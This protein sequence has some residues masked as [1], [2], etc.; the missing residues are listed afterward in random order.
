MKQAVQ[1]AEPDQVC[2]PPRGGRGLKHA[3]PSTPELAYR[4]PP[5]RGAWIETEYRVPCPDCRTSRPPRG[6]RGLKPSPTSSTGAG[7]SVAPRAGGVD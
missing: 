7:Y 4:S 5:A 3:W 6:G 2:R 1:T